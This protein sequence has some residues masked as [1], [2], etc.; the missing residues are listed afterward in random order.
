M[1]VLAYSD[2]H[3]GLDETLLELGL[4]PNW[5]YSQ[6]LISAIELAKPNLVICCGDFSEI[7]YD[8]EDILARRFSEMAKLRSITDIFL[9]GNH[10]PVGKLDYYQD[11]VRY[12]H[13]HKLGNEHKLGWDYIEG[14]HLKAEQEPAMIVMGHTHKPMQGG[15]FMD[16][17]SVT[18]CGT[19]GLIDNGAPHLCYL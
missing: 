12:M 5:D 10:D 18:L 8:D 7:Y 2:T 19:Y 4:S 6:K 14:L 11:N 3:F 13:G 17:G 1:R 15:A 9:A 16:I